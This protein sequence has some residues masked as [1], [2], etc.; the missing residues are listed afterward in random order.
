MLAV[1]VIVGGCASTHCSSSVEVLS[2]SVLHFEL[3]RVTG[4]D[5]LV[6]LQV[7]KAKVLLHNGFEGRSTV[8]EAYLIVQLWEGQ[9]YARTCMQCDSYFVGEHKIMGHCQTQ[10]I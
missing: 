2:F 6:A 10:N 3:L 9:M 4:I 7:L 8:E 5:K 1:V